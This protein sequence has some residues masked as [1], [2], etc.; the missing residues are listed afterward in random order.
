MSEVA[1]L[2]EGLS[3]QYRIGA[4]AAA[5]STF[6][7]T[8]VDGLRAPFRRAVGA[9]RGERGPI[10]ARHQTI[11]ALSD[12]SF[13]FRR[14]DVIGIIGRNGSGKS[15]LL[16]IL[17]GITEP[18][19]GFAELHGRP[20]SLLEVGVGFHPELTGRETVFLNGAIIGMRRHEI[21]KRFDEIVAFSG[22]EKFIDTQVKFYSSGMYLRLAF[23][24]T[25]HMEAEILLVDEVLAVGDLEFQRRCLGRMEQISRE[26][27]TVLFVSH[28]MA[29]VQ[30]LCQKGL[31]LDGGRVVGMGTAADA[32]RLYRDLASAHTAGAGLDGHPGRPGRF[33]RPILRGFRMLDEGGRERA[34]FAMGENIV[35]ELELEA[36]EPCADAYLGIG[37]NSW[38]GQRLCTFNSRQQSNEAIDLSARRV[39]RCVWR[40]CLLLAGTY[41]VELWVKRAQEHLDLVYDAARFEVVTADVH[42]TGKVQ[43]AAGV[44]EARACWSVRS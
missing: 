13:D 43:T 2:A 9:L 8:L 40:D 36:Q 30:H 14:G 25:S 31:V 38:T 17:T 10:G 3:K 12:V 29:A 39:V 22:V 21:E 33:T 19:R 24:V 5:Y 42:G 34:S 4:R 26:G 15:T 28:D 6:R 41:G 44:F 16:K 27:R 18:T 11:W 35:F 20:G 23:A 32:I 1:V 37:V 7:E